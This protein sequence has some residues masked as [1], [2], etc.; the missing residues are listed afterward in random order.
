MS[1]VNKGDT[2]MNIGDAIVESSLMFR[3]GDEAPTDGG[4]PIGGEWVRAS[5]TTLFKEKRVLVFSLPG[6]YTPTCSTYQLPGFEENFEAI[7]DLGIDE[8]YVASVNDAFV[9]NAWAEHLGIKNVKV[10]PDGNGSFC[11]SLGML[12]DMTA[13]GFGQRS[14]RFAVV[15]NN[16]HLE[17]MFVEPVATDDNPDPYGET[18]PETIMGYLKEKAKETAEEEA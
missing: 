18:S 6:A 9:M 13:V 7:K 15:I 4:C 1:I 2:F 11:G 10:L 3:E 5:T 8:I 17:K 16:N 12:E 14:R